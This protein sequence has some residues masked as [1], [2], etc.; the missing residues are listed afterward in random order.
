[1]TISCAS[2]E[3]V[4]SSCPHVGLYCD[5]ENAGLQ[6]QGRVGA[7]DC[8]SVGAWMLAVAVIIAQV[9]ESP[10]YPVENMLWQ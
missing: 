10:K 6:K 8:I 1:M 9:C 7:D 4:Y 2:D 5:A 3:Q